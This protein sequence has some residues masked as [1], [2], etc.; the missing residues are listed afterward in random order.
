MPI[1]RAKRR[2]AAK[3][4]IRSSAR[5]YGTG[6]LTLTVPNAAETIRT[7]IDLTMAA[8]GARGEPVS[9]AETGGVALALEADALF[10]RTTSNAAAGLAAAGADASRLRLGL[11]GSYV[12]AVAGGAALT[13]SLGIGLRRDGGERRRVPAWNSAATSPSSIPG[14]ALPQSSPRTVC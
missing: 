11:E 3:T 12:L 2:P 6:E 10:A 5:E 8:M 14:A 1:R 13:P 7:G 9:P 4:R